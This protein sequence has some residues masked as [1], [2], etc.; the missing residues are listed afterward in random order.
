MSQATFNYICAQLQNEIERSDT[1]MRSSIPAQVRVA[2]TV[3]YLATDADYRTTGHLFGISKASVCLIRKD[4]C[5]A[6]VKVLLPKYIKIPAGSAL[7][8]VMTGFEKRGFPHCGGTIDGTHIPI[9]APQDS[10]SDYH[11]RK[12]LHS[13]ILQVMLVTLEIL[14]TFV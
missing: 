5:H 3:W 6:I 8:D 14:L 4:V 7:T 13:V 9:E 1:V 2:I 10:P 12:G 11:N